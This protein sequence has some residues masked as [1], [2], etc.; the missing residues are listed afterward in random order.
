MI[1]LLHSLPYFYQI[2]AIAIY[3]ILVYSSYGPEW[4]ED[5]EVDSQIVE[6]RYCSMFETSFVFCASQNNYYSF[7]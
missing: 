6:I 4:L 3:A 5:C 1:G 7:T 2:A